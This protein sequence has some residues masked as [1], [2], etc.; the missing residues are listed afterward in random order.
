MARWTI[1]DYDLLFATHP[2]TQSRAPSA[3][4]AVTLGEQLGRTGDAVK[5][6]WQDARDLVLG[7]KS[8]A[9]QQ[10]RDYARQRRWISR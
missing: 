1:D 5:A 7:S 6:Q 9:S 4:E 3:E 8:A 2:P 10:L